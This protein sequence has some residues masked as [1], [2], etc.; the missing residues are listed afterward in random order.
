MAVK[1]VH[2]DE[3]VRRTASM[4]AGKVIM[5]AMLQRNS[6]SF[7]DAGDYNAP[8]IPREG[9]RLHPKSRMTAISPGATPRERPLDEL[10]RAVQRRDEQAFG[11]LY[12]QTVSQV[13]GLAMHLLRHAADAEEIVCQVF[14]RAWLRA[15]RY[16]PDRGS[17][18]AWLLVMCRSR[19]LDALKERR[20]RAR[21]DERAASDEEEQVED[22]EA[23]L[24]RFQA[25]SAVHRAVAKLT[26]LR[27]QL[28][29]LAFFRDL[30][31]QE[32]ADCLALP[33]GTVKSH[34]RR[35]LAQLRDALASE[36]AAHE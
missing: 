31:H 17:V 9:T 23:L 34:M 26:P 3:A 8:D 19:A 1:S 25:G 24:S 18:M 22:P 29:A 20:A 32:M 4:D 11:F 21:R 28:V 35:G 16:D 36:G 7:L 2:P 14:E 13:Y 15:S 30:S 5:C 27:R 10:M 33:L 12:E 6:E